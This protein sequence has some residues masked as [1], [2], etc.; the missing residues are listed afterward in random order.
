MPGGGLACRIDRIEG[1][2]KIEINGLE[3]GGARIG[4]VGRQNFLAIGAQ[5]ENLTVKLKARIDSPYHNVKPYLR[6]SLFSS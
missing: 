6:N 4:D 2:S 5:F 1:F 3:P